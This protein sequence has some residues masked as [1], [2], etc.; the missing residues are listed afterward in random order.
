MT[1][2][3]VRH[4]HAGSRHDWSGIDS[5]RPL[6]RRGDD[7]AA[8]IARALGKGGVTRVLSSPATRCQQTVAPLA[9][10]HRTTVEVADA[11]NEGTAVNDSM[12]LLRSVLDVDAVLCSHGDV[13]PDLIRALVD[14]GAVLHG[15]RHPTKGS[16]YVLEVDDGD[17]VSAT[18]VERSTEGPRAATPKKLKGRP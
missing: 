2:Y 11:L 9:R 3:L 17:V 13:I 8:A 7:E 1:I 6:S 15:S 18:Y 5:Q 4:A 10:T 16:F 14:G 12:T